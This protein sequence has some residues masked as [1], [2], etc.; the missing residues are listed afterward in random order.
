MDRFLS[1]SGHGIDI[2]FVFRAGA[3]VPAERV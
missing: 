2:A 3:A 1:R